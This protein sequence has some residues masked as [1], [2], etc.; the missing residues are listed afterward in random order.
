MKTR[1]KECFLL[2]LIVLFL[3]QPCIGLAQ[4]NSTR[5]IIQRAIKDEMERNI[6]RLELEDME[7]PFF[8][9]YNI[10]DV[11]TFEVNSSLGAIINSNRIH[12]R[13]YNVRVIVGDYSLNDENFRDSGYSY[14]SSMLQ[15]S[16]RLPL[17]DDYD[18]I[19]R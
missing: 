8:I 14:R 9:S 12:N 3:F 16:S 5:D 15:G 10:Y 7:R 2:L 1:N 11:K 6:S 4:K 17:E 18:G 13:N 19:R